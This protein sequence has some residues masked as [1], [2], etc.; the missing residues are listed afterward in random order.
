MK[1]ELKDLPNCTR[2]ERSSLCYN[3]LSG[4]ICGTPKVFFVA[5]QP[6]Y[7]EDLENDAF[8]DRAGYNFQQLLKEVGLANFYLTYIIKCRGEAIKAPHLKCC[9]PWFAR[10]IATLSPKIVAPLGIVASKAVLEMGRSP[11]M[12]DIVS[13]RIAKGPYEIWPFH[14]LN[15]LLLAKRAVAVAWLKE[16]KNELV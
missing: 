16:I 3:V 14:G 11:K 8:S 9:K 6:T 5:E 1:L 15:T 12:E 10:E 13:K 2:C 4:K 7:Y